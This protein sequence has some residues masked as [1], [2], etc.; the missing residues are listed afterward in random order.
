MRAFEPAND[1]EEKNFEY[2]EQAIHPE[3]TLHLKVR[4]SHDQ[5]NFSFH[6]FPDYGGCVT[7][8]ATNL[9]KKKKKL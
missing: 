7:M 6:A 2:K 5:G 1:E 9:A 3:V 4:V 8:I